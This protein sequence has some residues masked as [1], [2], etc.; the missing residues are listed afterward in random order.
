VVRGYWKRPELTAERFLADPFRA[1]AGARM[2]RTGDLARWRPDGSVDFL[3]RADH[4]V[5]IRGYR[6]ELGEIEAALAAQPG[7]REAVV[8]A[9]EDA[10]GDKRLVA[11]VV[12][13]TGAVARPDE[14]RAALQQRLPDFMVPAHVVVLDALPLTPNRKVDRKALP[15]PVAAAGTS[16]TP[17][18]PPSDEIE[19]GIARVWREV[20]G[21]PRVGTSDN[22][23]DLGGH[24][25]LAVK[26]HRRLKETFGRELGITTLFRFPTVRELAQHLRGEGGP[27]LRQSH[28]RAE[29][30]RELMARRRSARRKGA[31]EG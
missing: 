3:G 8:V 6:V 5:K 19:E 9:R 16:A 22:F 14:L 26:V 24:S 13:R 4:Q 25:L 1:D 23:F 17:A 12:A 27:S 7:V 29:T 11:Y 21:V 20:L 15:P 18:P 10:P 28:E 30:R 31:G 2:Y